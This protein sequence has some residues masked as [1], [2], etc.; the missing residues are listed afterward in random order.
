LLR[1]RGHYVRG[2]AVESLSCWT[3]GLVLAHFAP[4]VL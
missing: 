3:C 2:L 4:L 1:V